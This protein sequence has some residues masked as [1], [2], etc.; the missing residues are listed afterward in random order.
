MRRYYR[1]KL[2]WKR[3][4]VGGAV[5]LGAGIYLLRSSTWIPAIAWL[6]ALA[7]GLLLTLLLYALFLLPHMLYRQQP[8]LK[9]EYR[10]RFEDDGIGFQTDE[11]VAQLK[12]VIYHSWI[13]DAEFYILY[14]GKRDVSVIPRRA[15]K[16]EADKNLCEL[17]Q[18]HIGAEVTT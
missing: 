9:S 5:A 4:L 10:L 15:L 16:G 2:Q 11:I 14:H 13:R 1:T 7:G 8:K 12:W 18:Q 6:L 17:L 3:D